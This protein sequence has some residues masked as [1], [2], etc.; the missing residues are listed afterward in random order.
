M[1]VSKLNSRL[2]VIFLAVASCSGAAFAQTASTS[3]AD[4]RGI[5]ANQERLACYDAAMAR[6]DTGAKDAAAP[7]AP[8]APAAALAAPASPAASGPR[9]LE[10]TVGA[11]ADPSQADS[12]VELFKEIEG[13]GTIEPLDA[14]RHADGIRRFKVTTTSTDNDLLDLFT[15]HIARELM[16]LDP[17]DAGYGFFHERPEAPKE[18]MPPELGYG[19]RGAGG[20]IPPNATLVFE[21]ELLGV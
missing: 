14:G 9:E 11:L 12:L 3:L 2:S 20:V 1:N 7:P 6:G 5:A 16:R 21:V 10:L 17:M 19:A 8:A 4:C 18:E 13:L 15:F